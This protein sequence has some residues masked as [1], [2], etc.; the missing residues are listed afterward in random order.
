MKNK[1]A[2]YLGVVLTAVMVAS[3]LVFAAPAVAGTL[4]W[5]TQSTPGNTGLEVPTTA[6]SY[7]GPV[8]R[9]KADA[10]GN[11]LFAYIEQGSTLSLIRSTDFGRNWTVIATP[12]ARVVSIVSAATDANTLYYATGTTVYKSTNALASTGVAFT[13]EA[14]IVAGQTITSMDATLFSGRYLVIVGTSGAPGNVY[15]LDES[16]PFFNFILLGTS[17]FATAIGNNVTKV[18]AVYFSPNYTT[19]RAVFA[20][21]VNGNSTVL[22]TNVLGGDWTGVIGTATLA[23]NTTGFAK[24][25]FPSDFT[26]AANAPRAYVAIDGAMT[27]IYQFIGGATST[28]TTNAFLMIPTMT[29]QIISFSAVGA[30][31]A[32]K[33]MV[34]TT[35]GQ[36]FLTTVGGQPWTAP[37]K[38]PTGPSGTPTQVVLNYVTAA[39]LA[40]TTPSGSPTNDESG[41]SLTMDNG[42]TYNQISLVN[43]TISN[44]WALAFGSTYTYASASRANLPV[45]GG[46]FTVSSAGT[47]ASGFTVTAPSGSGDQLTITARATGLISGLPFPTDVKLSVTSGI[48]GSDFTVSAPGA[49]II[50]NDI[51][52]TA[53]GQVATFTALR[54]NTSTSYAVQV[55]GGGVAGLPFDFVNVA[56]GVDFNSNVAWSESIVGTT[57]VGTLSFALPDDTNARFTYTSTGTGTITPSANTVLTGSWAGGSGT[58]TFTHVGDTVTF[59]TTSAGAVITGT[60]VGINPTGTAVTS[61]TTTGGPLFTAPLTLTNTASFAVVTFTTGYSGLVVSGTSGVGGNWSA[62]TGVL[63][64]NPGVGTVTLQNSLGTAAMVS[65][66]NTGAVTATVS[67][68]IVAFPAVNAPVAAAILGTYADSIWRYDGVA[69]WER[70]TYLAAQPMYVD[71]LVVSTTGNI[72]YFAQSGSTTIYKSIDNDQNWAAMVFPTPTAVYS[73][74]APDAVTVISGGVNNTYTSLSNGFWTTSAVALGNVTSMAVSSTTASTIVAGGTLGRY[75]I[76]TNNGTTW[77]TPSSAIAAFNGF[78]MRVAFENGSATNVYSIAMGAPGAYRNTTRVDINAAVLDSNAASVIVAGS[79]IGVG[80]ANGTG[81]TVAYAQ[82]SS[83]SNVSRITNASGSTYNAGSIAPP[84]G[85]TSPVGMWV[86]AA[87]SGNTLYTIF[88]ASTPSI[89]MYTDTLALPSTGV[90]APAATVLANSA[91]VTWTALTG[92]TSYQASIVAGAS[93][94]ALKN[95]Y[96]SNALPGTAIVAST[97]PLTNTFTGLTPNTTYTVS[98]WAV[99]PLVSYYSSVTFTTPVLLT[100]PGAITGLVPAPGATN[101]PVLASF[102][103]APVSSATGYELWLGT[104]PTFAAHSDFLPVTNAYNLTTALSYSGDYYWE[105]RATAA[106]GVVGP[107]SG[108]FAFSTV[109]LAIPPVTVTTN[110][111]ATITLIPTI[112]IPTYP[113]PVT[114]TNVAP[115]TPIITVPVVVTQLPAETPPTPTYIWIIVAVGAVLTLAVIILIIRTR[116]VV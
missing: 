60:A 12:T 67:G 25:F 32:P 105:V 90:T 104:D 2:K 54:P 7:T 16:A 84:S 89:R 49:T 85:A 57:D 18:L 66:T 45:N 98:V 43:T 70:T 41:V 6:V 24:M 86:Q 34:G 33:L 55:S 46:A 76:S 4:S 26:M 74:M 19:D 1:I 109:A 58:V 96:T 36:V 95:P 48:I 92:A 94:A 51:Y 100:A 44:Y 15:Y 38:A 27:G 73:I 103:W 8:T 97:A 78:S 91:V 71:N 93:T 37:N 11:T 108:P 9:A 110:P 72:L 62:G 42:L 75:A 22:G 79:G 20:I 65:A 17:D 61:G 101:V 82:D 53:P 112:V 39:A 30:F 3:I 13:P 23:T 102:A 111:Q 21:G 28:L 81:N 14:N 35:T 59:T 80:I 47:T 115:V 52:L 114:I 64:F 10:T 83:D 50:G 68:A 77:G 40:I 99:A 5:T 69:N 113:A 107:W 56:R 87:A 29:G 88:N 31:V 106:G 116:R 63:S